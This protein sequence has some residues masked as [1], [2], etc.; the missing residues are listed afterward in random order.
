MNVEDGVGSR[1]IHLS[2]QRS[3]IVTTE[4]VDVGVC[5]AL[6][7]ERRNKIEAEIGGGLWPHRAQ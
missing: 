4:M 5:G 6:P 1:S 2:L 7:L 3:T